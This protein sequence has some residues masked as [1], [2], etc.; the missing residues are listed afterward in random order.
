MYSINL[1]LLSFFQYSIIFLFGICLGSFLNVVIDRF[2]TNRSVLKGRSYCEHCKRTLSA[3]DLVPIFSFLFLQGKC[4]SCNKKIP[5]RLFLVELLGG[6]TLLYLFYQYFFLNIASFIVLS[7][8][9]FIFIA[10]FFIDLEFGIIPDK[11]SIP[12]TIFSVIYVLISGNNLYIHVFAA[13]GS[14]LFFMCLFFLTKGRGMGFGDVKI[15]FALGMILGFPLVVYGLYLAFLTGAIVLIILVLWKKKS[16]K[17]ST[18]PFGP[19]LV[20][21]TLFTMFF[22]DIFIHPLIRI[23][24]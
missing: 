5:L 9:I 22:S 12:L 4:R 1:N 3:I 10:I 11:L 6:A 2:A 20:G 8:I 16:F 14:L 21:S 24:F 23:L 13:F 7:I 18:V 15:S 17:K 19:F